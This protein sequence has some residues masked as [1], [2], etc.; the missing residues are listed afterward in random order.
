MIYSANVEN[1]VLDAINS[2]DV[3]DIAMKHSEA[4][5][6]M[7]LCTVI[8]SNSSLN[9]F[10]FCAETGIPVPFRIAVFPN[11]F[12][13]SLLALKTGIKTPV[14]LVHHVT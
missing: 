12:P 13:L 14:L 4:Y 5:Y 11:V 10:T 1:A 2:R 9:Y 7:C 6:E 8:F 3:G